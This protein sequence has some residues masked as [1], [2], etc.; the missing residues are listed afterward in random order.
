MEWMPINRKDPMCMTLSSH[1]SLVVGTY[2][3][4]LTNLGENII[5]NRVIHF[6]LN[7]YH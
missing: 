6:Y 2:C 1:L 4:Y 7:A 3:I 5:T